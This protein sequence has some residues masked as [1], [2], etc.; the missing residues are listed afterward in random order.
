MDI[1]VVDANLVAFA[2]MDGAWMDL[3]TFHSKA[4]TSA[5]FTMDTATLTPLVK[6]DARCTTLSTVMED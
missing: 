6:P 4:K 2:R 3:L 1:C 5:W